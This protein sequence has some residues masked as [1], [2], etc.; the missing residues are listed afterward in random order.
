MDVRP[1]QPIGEKAAEFRPGLRKGLG[2]SGFTGPETGVVPQADDGFQMRRFERVE[3]GEYPLV[4]EEN[5]T[6]RMIGETLDSVGSEVVKDRDRNGV[7]SSSSQESHRPSGGILAAEGYFVPGFQA[8]ALKCKM[9]LLQFGGDLR[10]AIV[11]SFV[12]AEC[13][14]LPLGKRHLFEIRKKMSHSFSFFDAVQKYRM[15]DRSEKKAEI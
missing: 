12:I 10:V 8:Q 7:I 14:T 4:S 13:G 1:F 15:P 11:A 9:E 2:E 5:H 3:V 6:F